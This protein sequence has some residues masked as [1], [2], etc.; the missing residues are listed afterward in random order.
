MG[1]R[2]ERLS[3]GTYASMKA[4]MFAVRHKQWKA[5]LTPYASTGALMLIGDVLAA[6]GILTQG[7]V[8]QI[9]VLI[10]LYIDWLI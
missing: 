4:C 3:M 7:L 10:Y 5:C 2:T 1:H 8:M 6:V 9:T